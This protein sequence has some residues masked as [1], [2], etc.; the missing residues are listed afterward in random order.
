[1]NEPTHP[2]PDFNNRQASYRLVER[3]GRTCIAYRLPDDRPYPTEVLEA[4]RVIRD[5]PCEQLPRIFEIEPARVIAEYLEGYVTLSKAGV[6]STRFNLVGNKPRRFKRWR[7]RAD[8]RDMSRHFES[9]IDQL[10]A[11]GD[12]LREHG[13]WHD[14]VIPQNVM[15]NRTLHRM[16]LIDICAFCPVE[17]VRDGRRAW[18]GDGRTR[19]VY[20]AECRVNRDYVREVFLQDLAPWPVVLLRKLGI[21]IRK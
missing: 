13:L 3:D 11:L 12:Y 1:M 7:L 18:Y 9:F 21:G 5:Q 19:G 6:T 2:L 15:W 20:N 17:H 4:L 10:R 8:Q 16:K 14:D